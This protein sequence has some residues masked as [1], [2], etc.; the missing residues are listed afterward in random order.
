[1][2][3][4]LLMVPSEH[5]KVCSIS[6]ISSMPA[7]VLPVKELT[8][9]CRSY[10]AKVIIDGAHVIGN[11]PVDVP[12]IE[13]D[14]YVSNGH[15]WFFTPKGAAFIWVNKMSQPTSITYQAQSVVNPTIISNEGSGESEYAKLFSWE[16]T[17]GYG[18]FFAFLDAK[19]WRENLGDKKIIQYNLDLATRGGE[20][21]AKKWNTQTLVPSGRL[22]SAMVNI[23]LPLKR[24]KLTCSEVSSS[25]PT[26]L[27]EQHN[28]WVP[29]VEKSDMCLT[30]ISAQIYND[31]S[32]FEFVGDAINDILKQLSSNK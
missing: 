9:L 14:V 3:A 2:N 29:V 8:S 24:W 25:L 22:V 15:K 23:E 28:T 17:K 32:D 16:G 1:V 10:G 6:H 4:S 27:L 19:K 11:I 31:I 7:V 30:R 21:L 26:M 5:T 13:A 18:S 12:S 20:L